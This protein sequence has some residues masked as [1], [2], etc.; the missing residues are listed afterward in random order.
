M[1]AEVRSGSRARQPAAS[2]Q[3]AAATLHPVWCGSAAGCRRCSG[4]GR[5]K[6]PKL[7]PAVAPAP[8]ALRLPRGFV[9]QATPGIQP[10]AATPCRGHAGHARGG[11]PGAA[12]WVPGAARPAALLR[13][14]S[15]ASATC[16]GT[17]SWRR[18][19][20][21]RCR[22]R[23]RGPGR[24]AG[25]RAWTGATPTAP[26]ATVGAACRPGCGHA[27]PA[28]VPPASTACCRPTPR[29]HPAGSARPHVPRPTG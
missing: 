1:A 12:G 5:A 7:A 11:D 29:A 25:S 22:Q 3:G 21:A 2:L 18:P 20:P 26:Y 9:A 17:P 23:A 10:G 19:R 14:G 13:P 24:S 4:A 15:G 28:T 16:P 8:A 6:V 27:G